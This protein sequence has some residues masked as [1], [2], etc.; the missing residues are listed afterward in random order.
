MPPADLS[1]ERLALNFFAK[2]KYIKITALGIFALSIILALL[3]SA[4]KKSSELTDDPL[5]SEQSVAAKNR[6]YNFLLVGKDDAANL[7][8]VIIIVSYDTKTHKIE[9]LQIPRDTYA[10]YTSAS[11]R[12]LNGAMHALGGARQL[13]DFLE[14]SLGIP[15]DYYATV[16]IDTISDTVDRLGGVE[17]NIAEDMYYNDP[18]Q[19]LAIDL[20][21]G[22]HL[23]SGDQAV[24]FLRYRAGYLRGD[25]GRLDAQKIFL[26]SLVKK[27]L[28]DSSAYDLAGIALGL[29][30]KLETNLN[31]SDCLYFISQIGNIKAE[32]IAFM[33]MPGEDIQSQS[34]AWYYIINREEAYNTV[35]KYF[36]PSLSECDFDKNKVFTSIYRQGFNKIYEA[37]GTYMTERYT[38]DVIC[39]D[40]INID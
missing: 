26:A 10:S 15:I 9:A 7:C 5:H 11:Y 12:K 4:P 6:S 29:I 1:A 8:D 19:D 13:A 21:A 34:G 17:I 37:K 20:K 14:E 38:A 22:K 16:D 2:R 30:D 18:Y 32:N 24:Q 23:L 33:T 40:G 36:S 28:T 3:L 31:A 25:I 35:K 27:I 39:R